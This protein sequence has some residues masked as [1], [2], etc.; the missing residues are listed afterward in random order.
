[1]NSKDCTNYLNR[2][3]EGL[4]KRRILHKTRNSN[5]CANYLILPSEGPAKKNKLCARTDIAKIVRITMRVIT[6]DSVLDPEHTPTCQ[7]YLRAMTHPRLQTQRHYA[8]WNMCKSI[9]QIDPRIPDTQTH[10][11][12]YATYARNHQSAR[13]NMRKS[14]MQI[15]PR[16]LTRAR[17]RACVIQQCRFRF[18]CIS[19]MFHGIVGKACMEMSKPLQLFSRNE[20]S[21]NNLVASH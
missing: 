20:T 17:G 6:G 11:L 1:M 9:M 18:Y 15:D 16:N 8:G 5:A 2:S 21:R 4:H 7:L 3:P 14:I 13:W 12:H 10:T 19:S